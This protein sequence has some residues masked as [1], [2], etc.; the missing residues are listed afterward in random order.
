MDII[1]RDKILTIA[2]EVRDWVQEKADKTSYHPEDL[3][4][5]C[6]I[7]SAELHRSLA[8][9]N[10]KSEIRLRD[11]EPCHAYVLVDDHVLDV[12]ATQFVQF[13][14]DTVVLLHAKEA[15]A[16]IF[17]RAEFQFDSPDKLRNHQIKNKWP[18]KQ[19]AHIK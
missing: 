7:A 8:K 6:A 14:H 9:V 18:R 1:M 17:Y 13:T 10:I 3:T 2:K 12:T 15:D 5:W 19:L 4:G 16:F 11:I